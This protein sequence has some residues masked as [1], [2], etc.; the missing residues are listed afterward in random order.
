MTRNPLPLAFYTRSDVVQIAK[1][2]LGKYLITA[3]DGQITSGMIVETEAYAGAIDKASHAYGNRRT[4][5]TEVMFRRG[6]IA[7]IYLCYGIHSLFNVV[8]N[9]EGIPHAVL[10]RGIRAVEG[11]PLMLHRAGKLKVD[12]N[13]GIGPGKVSKIL[14]LHYTYTGLALIPGDSTNRAIQSWIEDRGQSIAP[15]TIMSTPRIG[16]DYAGEH[17]KWPYRFTLKQ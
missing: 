8:T 13:F 10:I 7:Y 4:A 16:V 11:I 9:V 6:G 17:A 3:V 5:R 15:N 12:S 2:M 14:G 1:D